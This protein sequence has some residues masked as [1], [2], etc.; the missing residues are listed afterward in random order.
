MTSP[1]LL[2]AEPQTEA[3]QPDSAARSTASPQTPTAA[4]PTALQ[5][6]PIGASTKEHVRHILLGSPGAVQQTIHLL[7]TLRYAE[8][9]LWTPVLTI[10]DPL[11]IEPISGE[12]ISLLRKQI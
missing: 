5:L 12:A 2:T 1:Y 9:L 11:T 10:Q 8:T 3:R 4:P 6:A 7:H